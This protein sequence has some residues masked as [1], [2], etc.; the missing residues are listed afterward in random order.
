MRPSATSCANAPPPS[1][2]SAPS[3]T[4]SRLIVDRIEPTLWSGSALLRGVDQWTSAGIQRPIGLVA[5][6]RVDDLEI[7]PRPLRLLGLLDLDQIHVAHD[8]PVD[9]EPSIVGHEVIDRHLAH[10]RHHGKRI[11]VA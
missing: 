2:W 1:S 5:G 9:P 7:I 8:A 11:L 10:L 4:S 6:H 3:P